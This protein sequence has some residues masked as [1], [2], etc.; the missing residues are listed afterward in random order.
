MSHTIQQGFECHTCCAQVNGPGGA[1]STQAKVPGSVG[2]LGATGTLGPALGA[3]PVGVVDVDVVDVV[4]VGVV[5][6]VVVAVGVV[7]V[8][9]VAVGVVAVGDVT[10]DLTATGLEV[11]AVLAGE[12]EP[13]AVSGVSTTGAEGAAG[14]ADGR[15][16]LVTNVFEGVGMG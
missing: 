6:V 7:A 8:G 11:E 16:G 14:L 15:P 2:L 13:L 4:A 3:A 9:V 12:W 5:A 10:G 1:T